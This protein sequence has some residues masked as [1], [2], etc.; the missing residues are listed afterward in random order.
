MKKAICAILLTSTVFAQTTQATPA[1]TDAATPAP[2]TEMTGDAAEAPVKA[3]K[4]N[5][6]KGWVFAGVAL[7]VAA[8]AVVAVA[9]SEG[10]ASH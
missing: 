9:V 2:S 8:G 10:S 7:V 3:A 1:A 6:W 5:A 4:S